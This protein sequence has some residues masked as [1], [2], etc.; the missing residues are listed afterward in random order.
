M[1]L[2]FDNNIPI[3]IQLVDIIKMDIISG[4]IVPGEK[5]SSI[6]DLSLKYKVN[7]NTIQKAMSELEDLKL[8]YTERT[9]GKYVSNDKK[10]ID[11]LKEDYVK[12]ISRVYINNMIDLGY[13]FEDII[14]YI[15]ICKGDK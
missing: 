15:K 1:N 10:L 14:K 6:R 11:S 9:N 4:N 13:N 8:I 2:D 7:P 12:E 5:L 3:Y